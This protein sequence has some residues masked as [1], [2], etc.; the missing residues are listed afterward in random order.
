VGAEEPTATGHEVWAACACG[1]SWE[2]WI[3]LEEAF[4]GLDPAQ[5]RRVLATES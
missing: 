4:R 3:T 2:P 5:V 1:A